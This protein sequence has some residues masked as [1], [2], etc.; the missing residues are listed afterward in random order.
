[1]K[2]KR[3]LSPNQELKITLWNARIF[4]QVRRI[5][6]DGGYN[7]KG[8]CENRLKESSK[9]SNENLVIYSGNDEIH[10]RGVALIAKGSL[11]TTLMGLSPAN[12]RMM[13]ARFS[14]T[15][16]RLMIIVPYAPTEQEKNISRGSFMNN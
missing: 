3:P 7:L 11:K 14:F 16:R 12:D 2:K 6:E 10:E 9:I 8:L 13:W 5:T 4:H 15:Q 1:M